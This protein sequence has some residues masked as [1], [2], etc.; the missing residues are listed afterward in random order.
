MWVWAASH[1]IHCHTVRYYDSSKHWDNAW[2]A[3]VTAVVLSIGIINSAVINQIVNN[4]YKLVQ[5]G[6]DVSHL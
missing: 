6:D 1:W 2:P 5:P 4:A 3:A